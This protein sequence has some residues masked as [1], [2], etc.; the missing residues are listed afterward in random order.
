V[1]G[2]GAVRELHSR[3]TWRLFVWMSWP[4][5][6]LWPGVWQ[7]LP[8]EAELATACSRGLLVAAPFCFAASRVRIDAATAL[9]TVVVAGAGLCGALVIEHG[10]ERGLE[11]GV[12]ALALLAGWVGAICLARLENDDAID[13]VRLFAFVALVAPLAWPLGTQSAP[14]IA[15]CSPWSAADGTTSIAPALAVCALLAL[16]GTADRA[17]ARRALAP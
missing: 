12:A 5:I 4:W 15:R 6:A 17:L 3:M 1:L 11:R 7:L 10:P 2:S 14:W 13:R 16:L 9:A 8:G